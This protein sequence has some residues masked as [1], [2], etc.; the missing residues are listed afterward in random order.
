M[1]QLK[2]CI[3]LEVF[4]YPFHL[5]VYILHYEETVHIV[6]ISLFKGKMYFLKKAMK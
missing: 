3:N 6:K 1:K 2:K 4:I 5:C